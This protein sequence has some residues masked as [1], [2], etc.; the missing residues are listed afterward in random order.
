[1]SATWG[2]RGVLTRSSLSLT[3]TILYLVRGEKEFPVPLNQD[4]IIFTSWTNKTG[5]NK[6][7]ELGLL[8]TKYKPRKETRKV[9]DAN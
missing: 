8:K 9:G 7:S 6:R 1:M 4:L 5:I 2:E 3:N